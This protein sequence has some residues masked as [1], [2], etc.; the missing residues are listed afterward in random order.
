MNNSKKLTMALILRAISNT[1]VI[2]NINSIY[3]E[4]SNV[5]IIMIQE[6]VSKAIEKQIMDELTKLD[7]L[8]DFTHTVSKSSTKFLV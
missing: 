8:N 6:K 3:D 1:G 2:V 5:G 4:D 7:M